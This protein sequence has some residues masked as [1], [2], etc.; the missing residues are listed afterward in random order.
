MD[1]ITIDAYKRA[2]KRIEKAELARAGR[3]RSYVTFACQHYLMLHGARIVET[4]GT[5][6]TLDGDWKQAMRD[7]AKVEED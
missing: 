2:A 3:S 5:H 4:S 1:Y 7:A 6:I